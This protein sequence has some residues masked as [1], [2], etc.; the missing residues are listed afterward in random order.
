MSDNNFLQLPTS[1]RMHDDLI[2]LT[3][4]GK[5]L[6][7]DTL[8]SSS[9][10][11]LGHGYLHG[12]N[13]TGINQI[14]SGDYW[15]NSADISSIVKNLEQDQTKSI[16]TKQNISLSTN[17]FTSK[18]IDIR[19]QVQILPVVLAAQ[20]N[21]EEI[22]VHGDPGGPNVGSI[23]NSS[24]IAGPPGPH[25]PYERAAAVIAVEGHRTFNRDLTTEEHK[26][27]MEIGS[28]ATG[29]PRDQLRAIASAI[30][31]DGKYSVDTSFIEA[32]EGVK[33]EGYV[34]LNPDNTVMGNSGVTIGVGIDLGQQSV[35]SL[36][37]AGV[38]PSI[39][40]KLTPYL[41]LQ[42]DEA[43]SFVKQNPLSLSNPELTSLDNTFIHSQID[44]TATHFQQLSGKEF[45]S[46]PY[47]VK[48]ALVDITYQFPSTSSAPK[49]WDAV[50]REDW[51]GAVKELRNFYD[52]DASPPTGD[53]TRRAEEADRIQKSLETGELGY[54]P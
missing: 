9:S 47:E 25:T 39:I 50:G 3:Q 40:Q 26:H 13:G 41:G 15:K 54:S 1:A 24:P 35:E 29:T 42:R 14:T 30:Q 37:N 44:A 20:G 4:S 32:K 18:E 10:D 23:S 2:D 16:A 43:L 34:P 22:V 19:H 31:H 17:P 33:S 36:K 45:T 27:Y 49:F 21:S 51:A 7:L 48:T 46:L 38:D 8:H 6:S 11:Q 28:H 12:F 53:L 5:S 52:S